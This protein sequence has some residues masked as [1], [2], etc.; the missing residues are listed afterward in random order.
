MAPSDGPLSPPIW[1]ARRTTDVVS[2]V[3]RTAHTEQL[4]DPLPPKAALP[5]E[6]AGARR[7][8]NRAGNLPGESTDMAGEPVL[9]D[10]T[11]ERSWAPW[12]NSLHPACRSETP[13][14]C[15]RSIA[16]S[17][18]EA[19]SSPRETSPP[20]D[21]YAPHGRPHRRSGEIPDFL[22]AAARGL[23]TRACAGCRTTGIHFVRHSPVG[24]S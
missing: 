7:M 8:L 6:S 17:R 11:R 21:A 24:R 22:F 5:H 16:I 20:S 14:A 1:M 10:G 19:G 2:R 4:R 23:M 15:Q 9:R 13:R 12:L 18:C 3:L